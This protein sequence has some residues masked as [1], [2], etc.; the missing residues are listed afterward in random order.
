MYKIQIFQESLA[1]VTEE[2]EV[3]QAQILSGS[4]EEEVVDARCILIKIMNER[5]LY[6]IQISHLT[7]IC[8]RSVTRFL[9]GFMGRCDSRKIMRLNYENVKTKLGMT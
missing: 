3:E 6:P 2:T 7:G 4:K 8:K 5:G 9:V 1:A